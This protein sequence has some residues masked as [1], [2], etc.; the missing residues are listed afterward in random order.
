VE[1]ST[2]EALVTELEGVA[3]ERPQ[4]YRLRVLGL[5]LL[6]YAVLLGSIL[7]L[8]AGSALCIWVL[9]QTHIR[10]GMRF[11]LMGLAFCVFMLYYMLKSLWIRV[12]PPKGIVL[13]H[14]NAPVLMALIEDL[15]KKVGAPK[16]DCV[17]LDGEF[18]AGVMELPRLGLLGWSKT[19]LTIGLPL[20]LALNPAQLEAVL[21]HEFGHLSGNHTRF[22]NWIYRVRRT[23]I[24]LHEEL[25]RQ[26][27]YNSSGLVGRFLDWYAPFF[28]AYSFVFA[29][30]NEYEADRT[31][32]QLTTPNQIGSAL[33]TIAVSSRI[34]GDRYWPEVFSRAEKESFP[35]TQI[36]G[37]TATTLRRVLSTPEQISFLQEALREQTGCADTHPALSA[38]LSALGLRWHPP[39]S[40]DQNAAEH[41]FGA[42]LAS[43]S[44][45]LDER[46]REGVALKWSERYQYTQQV[47]RQLANWKGKEA[48][49][50]TDEAL[51]QALWVEEF[52]GIPTALPYLQGFVERFPEHAAGRYTLGRLQCLTEDRLGLN[53]LEQVIILDPRL[54][55]SCC[56]IAADFLQR[57]G[58]T[59]AAAT[60]LKR[61]DKLAEQLSQARRERAVFD[62]NSQLVPHEQSAQSLSLLTRQL[63]KYSKVKAAYFARKQ[64][65]LFP[66]T[67]PCFVLGVVVKRKPTDYLSQFFANRSDRE[68]TQVLIEDLNLPNETWIFVLNDA[69]KH[70]S[71]LK[72]KFKKLV[73]SR[74]F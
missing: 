48:E 3:Q 28:G 65:T 62:R 36:L 12:D 42:K 23:W 55:V 41:F 18:N 4:A 27:D 26:S 6:G 5:A 64:L 1:A 43:F 61:A 70:N 34:L 40:L 22:G 59:E 7:L 20:A 50:S 60:Y 29:R 53:N 68:F 52:E 69:D 8:L 38:R 17:I 71:F 51:Q 63:K 37:G 72:S 32:A 39:E 56:Q 19:Y 45:V 2:F 14:D 44:A 10:G 54:A 31:A 33:I 47:R 49:L 66:G 30:Q 58:Q 9:T 73:E 67:M 16:P 15:A 24:Q 13:G 21:A 35:P 74:L 46:W 25:C 11:S 57:S